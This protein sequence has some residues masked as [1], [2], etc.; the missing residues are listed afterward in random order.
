M[1]I[2]LAVMDQVNIIL[3]AVGGG[4]GMSGGGG[5]GAHLIAVQCVSLVLH[6]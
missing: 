2:Q 6:V 1:G 4:E 5:A 3:I